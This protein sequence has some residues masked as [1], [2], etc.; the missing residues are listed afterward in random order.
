[1]T[2][3]FLGKWY[4][5]GFIV[6][7]LSLFLYRHWSCKKKPHPTNITSVILSSYFLFQIIN[8]SI[9]ALRYDGKIDL[10]IFNN[11]VEVIIV[12][13]AISLWVT[14]DQL[15]EYIVKKPANNYSP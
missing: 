4:A 8:I 3:L 14:I 15:Y 13:M 7:I 11:S 9:T 2:Q 10:G 1:M 12:G 6:L 5:V